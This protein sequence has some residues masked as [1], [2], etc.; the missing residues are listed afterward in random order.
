MNYHI[1]SLEESG[2]PHNND[3]FFIS[4]RIMN[5]TGFQRII[6]T[7]AGRKCNNKC[8]FSSRHLNKRDHTYKE[9]LNLLDKP[10]NFDI[11]FDIM[12]ACVK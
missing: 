12:Y 2:R 11:K 4:S 7:S 8:V 5:G 3:G 6:L 9:F 1:L 10:L